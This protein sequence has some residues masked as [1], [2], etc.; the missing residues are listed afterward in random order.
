[1]IW[2]G[3]PTSSAARQIKAAWPAAPPEKAARKQPLA[4]LCIE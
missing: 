2:G 1:M 3:K 4:D